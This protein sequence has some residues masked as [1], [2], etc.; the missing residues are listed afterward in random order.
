[1]KFIAIPLVALDV[2][3]YGN[4]LKVAKAS[5]EFSLKEF[6]NYTNENTTLE[7]ALTQLG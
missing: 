5:F 2:T 3:G 6:F 7:T 1:M 4:T